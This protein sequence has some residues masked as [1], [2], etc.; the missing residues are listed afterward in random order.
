MSALDQLAALKNVFGS[1]PERRVAKLLEQLRST[2]LRDPEKLILLH[3][4]ALFLRAYPHSPRVLRLADQILFQYPERLRGVDPAPFEAAEVSGIAGSAIST[5]YSHS[6]AR[7]LSLRHGKNLKIDWEN[8]SHPDR[9]GPVLARLAPLAA[10][11]WTVEPHIDWE[12][13]F[14]ALRGDLRWL[15]ENVDSWT[16][17]SLELLL[18]FQIDERTSRSH[19]RLSRPEVFYQ[20]Q[21]LLKRR[22]VS[23]ETELASPKIPTRR[24]QGKEAKRVLDLTIDTSAIR[25]RELWG[26]SYPDLK[27]VYHVDLGRGVDLYWLGIPPAARLPL[28]AYHGGIFF[29][30]GVPLGY[31]ETL[32]FFDRMEVGFNLYYTFREGESAWL[33]ARFLKFCQQECGVTCFSIDPYQV[34]H[35]NEEAVE[36][37]AFWFYRKLGFCSASLEIQA[38]VEREEKK[39]KADPEYRTSPATLRRLAK[40]PMLYGSSLEDWRGFS[41]RGFAQ[42]IGRGEAWPAI[43]RRVPSETTAEAI[44]SKKNAPEEIGYLRLLQRSPKLRRGILRLGQSARA[45]AAPQRK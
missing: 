43:V 8:Y 14:T 25:Y 39:L 37:G 9:L 13:W 29:K 23:L 2:R 45:A 12:R 30:N 26:F 22:D 4:T 10:E 31:I 3:E 6:F 27:H 16:Y 35:E 40:A 20:K 41:L 1:E 33:Y 21:P 36:S 34:G 38:E 15:I 28:R 42:K 17:D 7:F 32:S 5:N 11:D 18:L 44:L 24:L 19:A